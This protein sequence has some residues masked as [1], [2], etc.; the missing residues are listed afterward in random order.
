MRKVDVRRA[1]LM[2]ACGCRRIYTTMSR[3]NYPAWGFF[4]SLVELCGVLPSSFLFHSRACPRSALV[5][6]NSSPSS[7]PRSSPRQAFFFVIRMSIYEH[8]AARGTAEIT[9]RS[10]KSPH[11]TLHAASVRSF[12]HFHHTCLTTHLGTQL[13][14]TYYSRL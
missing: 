5:T 4:L 1:V 7:E 8:A 14:F 2:C 9:P 11:Q 10:G 3:S 6:L 12:R 13:C